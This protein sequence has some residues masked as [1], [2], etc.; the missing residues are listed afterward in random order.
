MFLPELELLQY[1]VQHSTIEYRGV[2]VRRG[3]V[4][5]PRPPLGGFLLSPI[6]SGGGGT[7]EAKKTFL[8]SFTPFWVCKCPFN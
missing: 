7:I 1:S 6:L 4:G 8:G 5:L 2:Q 3:P